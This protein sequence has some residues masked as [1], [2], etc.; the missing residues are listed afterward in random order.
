MDPATLMGADTEATDEVRFVTV[1]PAG[2]EVRVDRILTDLTGLSRSYLQKLIAA[3]HLTSDGQ[4]LRANDHVSGGAIL[5]LEVPR[6][7][8][9]NPQPEPDIA[10]TIVHEDADLLIVDKPAG[11]VVHPGA[12]HADGTLVN[13]LL[14]RA[15]GAE[16]GGIAGVRRPGIVHRLDRDTSGLLMVAR[17][18]AAQA[19]LMSQLK[20][21]RVKKTYLAL[22]HGNVAAAV[23]RVE[24]PVGRD[25]ARRTR[26]AVVANGRPAVTGYRVRDRFPGWTLLELDLVT[27]RTHQIRVHLAAIGHP[28]AGDPL[29]GTGTSRRGPDGL[30]RLFLHAWRLE[31]ASPSDGHLI[32]AES[33]L[34]AELQEVLEALRE[35]TGEA[36]A[37]LSVPEQGAQVSSLRADSDFATAGD[38]AIA[39]GAPGAMLVIIS[40][41]SGVGKDTVIAALRQRNHVPEY[42]Y[43]VTCTTRP[44]RP[45]EV[46]GV[47][48]RFLDRETFER[49]EREGEFLEANFVHD[50]WYGTPRS[51]VRDALA[52]G[53]HVILK[54]D[55]QGAQVV[56]EKVDDALLIFLVPPS[57]EDLF[58]RLRTRATETADELDVRQRN[59][60]I[61]LARQDD[62]DYVVVNE[63]DEVIAVAARVDEII[64]D[65]Q[66]RRRRRRIAI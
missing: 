7:V 56:K 36:P 23:G 21:R 12:G 26:M 58:L 8:A 28:V 31:L 22:V 33:P 2:A 59:A 43:V 11:L 65:E 49:L 9:A 13:A 42:H 40:G 10:V 54:I 57:L 27:G 20:A 38:F 30:G 51:Q 37:R 55:V 45:Y 47:H 64:A 50:N 52:A 39:S 15:G 46:D 4:P 60:A 63:T 5:R 32:R 48:Y 3:G 14:G 41:P 25:P 35:G 16:Y 62:Y 66:H 19:S 61:E 53:R 6:P 1:P 18:D 44:R 29:Y 24:A 17:H 34:P